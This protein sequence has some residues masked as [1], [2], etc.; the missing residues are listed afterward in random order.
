MVAQSLP[1]DVSRPLD[2]A[3]GE[4]DARSEQQ[5]ALVVRVGLGLAIAVALLVLFAYAAQ[6]RLVGTVLDGGTISDAQADA[7]DARIKVLEWTSVVLY[8]VTGIGWFVWL[9]RAYRNVRAIGSRTTD[10]SPGWAIGYW[11]IPIINVFR[12]YQIMKE[13][14]LRSAQCNRDPLDRNK[15]GAALIGFWW[16][17]W[18]GTGALSRTAGRLAR[19]AE[20]PAAILTATKFLML[21]EVL[22]IFAAALA[23]AIVMRIDRYQQDCQP[24]EPAVSGP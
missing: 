1:R 13:L 15:P 8:V 17:L 12:P 9:S 6:L 24:P 23:S 18:I 16:M 7:S 20:A 21:S 11:F 10:T 19:D 22:T 5:L 2:M 14:W 3:D 4:F